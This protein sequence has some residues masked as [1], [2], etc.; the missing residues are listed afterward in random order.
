MCS[1]GNP[2]SETKWSNPVRW[3]PRED[4]RLPVIVQSAKSMDPGGVH[5]LP[6]PMS[7]S[8]GDDHPING[9]WTQPLPPWLIQLNKPTHVVIRA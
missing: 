1:E 8:R 2:A 3:L 5:W 7:D 9:E 6:F 4:L